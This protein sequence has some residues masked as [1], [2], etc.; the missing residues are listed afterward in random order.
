MGV[1]MANK[2]IIILDGTS[3][4]W[5]DKLIGYINKQ[6]DSTIVKKDS[7]RL[8]RPT[9]KRVDL[10][11]H[12][13]SNIRTFGF[14]YE[15]IFANKLY[16][17]SKDRLVKA[18][19]KNKNIF[20][21][22]RN[23]SIIERIKNDFSEFNVFVVFIYSDNE[24]IT[25]VLGNDHSLEQSIRQAEEDYYSKPDL[26]DL[27]VINSNKQVTDFNRIASHIVSCANENDKKIGTKKQPMLKRFAGIIIPIL[28]SF[29]IGIIVNA[30][31]GGVFSNWIIIS[32]I[33]SLAVLIF[34][35]SI[36]FIVYK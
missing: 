18:I 30:L 19:E 17:F 20:I 22:I 32:I 12:A 21:V 34:L 3:A 13:N 11:L 27:V 1:K 36:L 2:N 8:K 28:C 23:Q 33:M 14:E 35:Y 25:S 9:D 16:G 5:K 7:N 29:P 10:Y 31:T 4:I 26:Y 15:Y 24:S 6:T